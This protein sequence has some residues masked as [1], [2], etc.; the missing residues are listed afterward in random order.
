MAMP[1]GLRSAT[2]EGLI[3][4]TSAGMI[5]AGVFYFDDLKSA[6]SGVGQSDGGLVRGDAGRRTAYDSRRQRDGGGELRSSGPAR[7]PGSGRRSGAGRQPGSGR[8]P[9]FGRVAYL[10]ADRSNQFYAKA[11]INGRPV[12]VLV[13]TG[14]SHVSLRYEDAERVGLYVSRSDFTHTART[15]NGTARIAPVWISRI[16]IGDI[17]V[18]DVQG[19]VGERGKKF[20]TLLGMA[21]LKRLKSVAIEGR[22][23]KLVQ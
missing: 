13:D 4:L 15:A 20:V 11:Y 18:R 5:F 8:Q 16:R 2:R 7:Q 10:R 22:S 17:M 19:Y 3:W 1:V 12:N 9:G 14:A 6:F 21:F 23:L